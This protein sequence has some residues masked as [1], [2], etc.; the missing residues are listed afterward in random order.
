MV[1]FLTS[2]NFYKGW[3]FFY[4]MHQKNKKYAKKYTIWK[5]Y[6]S[7]SSQKYVLSI[8]TCSLIVATCWN[9]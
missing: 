3:L 6:Q 2:A 9:V 8:V 1:K 7:I 5:F 4:I